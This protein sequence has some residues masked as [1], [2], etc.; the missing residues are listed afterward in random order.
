MA[1]LISWLGPEPGPR[2]IP[3]GRVARGRLTPPPSKS[4]THR[5]LD[6][7]LLSGREATVRRPLLAEDTR[8]FLDALAALGWRVEVSE[9]AARLAPPAR[10]PAAAEISC[11]NAGTLFRFLTATLAVLPGRW[12]LDGTPRLRERPIAPLVAAL[13]A[14]GARIEPAAAGGAPL[15][16]DGGALPGGHATLDAG[17]SSQYLSALLMAA[18]RAEGPVE[19]AVPAL[20]SRPYVA[21]TRDAI[22]RFTPPGTADP[23]EE[24][25]GGYRVRPA[26]PVPPPDLVVEGDFSAACYPAAAAA[27]T[28]G[29]VVLE[30]LAPDSAQGDRGFLDLLAR[31]G[32]RVAWRDGAVEVE[33]GELTGLAVDLSALPDQV[34]TLAA[35]APF[36]KGTT[37]IYNV[38]HLRIKESDRL[39][40]LATGLGRL[41]VPVEE[42]PD[43]L[44]IPGCWA[45]GAPPARLGS[46]AGEPVVLDP[47]GDHRIAM[48]F[49]LVGLRRPGVAVAHPEVVAKSYPGFW[50]DLDALL[51]AG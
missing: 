47:V 8:L 38:S 10:P 13:R 12:R 21:L 25:A 9:E 22:R 27:L 37:C 1:E 23:V 29:R 15:A 11:G 20:T 19:L 35:L 41:G 2:P 40:A 17:E 3:A 49:A 45:G 14:L 5:Y 28:G 30:G 24:L 51:G 39:R 42:L 16:I 6:L 7:V 48:S 34:P 50:R 26:R 36:A 32:A 31:M 43:G 33:G 4:V 44:R 18:L 46:P